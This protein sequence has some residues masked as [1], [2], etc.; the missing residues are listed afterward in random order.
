MN[1]QTKQTTKCPDSKV[2]KGSLFVSVL[3]MLFTALLFLRMEAMKR[4]REVINQRVDKIES[5]LKMAKFE[6]MPHGKYP[7]YTTHA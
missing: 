1:L 5:E 4:N 6:P 2:H 7:V 3:S